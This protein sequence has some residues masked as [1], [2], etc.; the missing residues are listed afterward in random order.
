MPVLCC[1]FSSGLTSP[2]QALLDFVS[3][4][5]NRMNYIKKIFYEACMHTNPCKDEIFVRAMPGHTPVHINV[6]VNFEMVS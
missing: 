2:N 4:E 3:A 6:E 5:I 1:A